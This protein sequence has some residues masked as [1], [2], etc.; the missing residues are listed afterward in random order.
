MVTMKTVAVTWGWSSQQHQTVVSLLLQ[1]GK[2]LVLDGL[3]EMVR[4]CPDK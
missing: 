1:K 4:T 2:V 3:P